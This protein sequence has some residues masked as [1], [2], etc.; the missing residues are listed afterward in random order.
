MKT[1]TIDISKLSTSELEKLLA[2]KR[3]EEQKLQDAKKR[4][5]EH[6]RDS[7]IHLCISQASAL[8]D[9]LRKF[10]RTCVETGNEL[11]DLMYEVYQKEPKELKTFSLISSDG[12]YKVEIDRAERQN[13]DETAEVH[14]DAIKEVLREKF[15][16]R[17]KT[18]YNIINDIL[19]KNNAGDY[20]ERLVAKLRKHET[21]INDKRFSDALDGLAK[22][23][24]VSGTSTYARFYSKSEDTNAWQHINIQFSSL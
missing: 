9:E 17:N 4:E 20:D 6:R 1:E 13:L 16:S 7:F 21:D 10:K 19:I 18:M 3:K 23:Y 2:D 5:Y 11:H 14:I 15:A 12:K 24:Y 22:S 8:H